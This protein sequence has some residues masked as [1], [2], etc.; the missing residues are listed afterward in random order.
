[1]P[2][3][4]AP[5]RTTDDDVRSLRGKGADD[6]MARLHAE[7]GE[8]VF[9]AAKR[10]VRDDEMAHDVTQEV[11]LDLWR[12]PERLDDRRGNVAALLTIQARSRAIDRVRS[13]ESRKRRE[14]DDARER[15]AV[16][17][18]AEILGDHVT[19]D[20]VRAALAALPEGQRTA[21]VDAYFGEHSYREVALRLGVAEGTI[22][23]R[24]RAGLATLRSTLAVEAAV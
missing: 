18:P 4:A 10:V 3:C 12:R 19:R 15:G 11:F 7:H 9:R 16:A 8:A 2:L 1:M 20:R 14:T 17:D 6:A 22:K 5:V 13:E 24:I 23:S 21:I